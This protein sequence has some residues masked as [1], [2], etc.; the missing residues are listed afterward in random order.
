[1]DGDSKTGANMKDV[2]AMLL[3]MLLGLVAGWY[4]GLHNTGAKCIKEGT[5]H[6]PNAVYDCKLREVK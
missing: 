4:A 5:F 6:T 3:A 1:M 2:A